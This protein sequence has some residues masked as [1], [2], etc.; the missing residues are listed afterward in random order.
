MP[1][2]K[3]AFVDAYG[4]LLKTFLDGA[5]DATQALL[6]ENI[7]NM[8]GLPNAMTSS[9]MKAACIAEIEGSMTAYD[10]AHKTLAP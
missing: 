6:H 2:T 8:K 9:E 10:E 5:K 7:E 4:P 3:Q 1:H